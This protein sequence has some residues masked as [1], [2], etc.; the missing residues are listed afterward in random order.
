MGSPLP[1]SRH[2]ARTHT[3]AALLAA[4]V[5]V[6]ACGGGGTT[7]SQ[8]APASQ[9]T[10]L[11]SQG[12]APVPSTPGL[13]TLANLPI[14]ATS[15]QAV[16]A[17]ATYDTSR[18]L[19]VKDTTPP[20]TEGDVTVRDI[21]YA[22]SSGE[23]VEAYLVV[24]SGDGPF[25]A[26][27]FLHWLGRSNSNRTEFLDEAKALAA[28][29]VVSLL[30]TRFFPGVVQPKDWQTDRASIA[31][32]NAQLRRGIDVLLAQKGVDPKRLAFVGHDYGAMN[33]TVLVA[34]D[35]RLK[36]AVLMTADTDWAN[37]FA[38]YFPVGGSIDATYKKAMAAFDPVAFVAHAAPVGLF[39]QFGDNDGFVSADAARRLTDAASEPRKAV[40]YQNVGH[41][42]GGPTD[43][44]E[45]ERDAWLLDQLGLS[46]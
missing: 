35:H 10:V 33:G 46:D 28:H 45:I 41:D 14:D 19:D 34:T 42:M 16:A 37:W 9:G 5:L 8:T 13:A 36:A 27:E 30:P 24:P 38:A 29:G 1:S 6:A 2:A 20:T 7:A 21:T 43:R 31:Q 40:T 4:V 17:L 18:P 44:P 22:G 15:D 39:L 23:R 3:A 32:Q 12:T 25:G 11:A 26:V